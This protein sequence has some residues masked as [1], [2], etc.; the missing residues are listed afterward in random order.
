MI[1]PICLIAVAA[2]VALTTNE[3]KPLFDPPAQHSVTAHDLDEGMQA[4]KIGGDASYSVR[5][6]HVSAAKRTVKVV[7][8]ICDEPSL[9]VAMHTHSAKSDVTRE[10]LAGALRIRSDDALLEIAADSHR[11]ISYSVSVKTE[12]DPPARRGPI[13]V[14]GGRRARPGEK[15]L[16]R[17]GG[18]PPLAQIRH[19]RLERT[20]IVTLRVV[21]FGKLPGL[22]VLTRDR[23]IIGRATASTSRLL[24][25]RS[26]P[27]G[28]Y[29][30]RIVPNA[31]E[32]S[33]VTLSVT[34]A[35]HEAGFT[36]RN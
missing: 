25:R 3:V 5:W 8:V 35:A 22:E 36:K 6:H 27:A 19:L 32:L 30:L 2:A 24:F 28:E 20:S 7:K 14:D 10:A 4:F 17:V 33:T 31:A 26:L 29:V 16:I 1:P 21:A 23:K 18:D 9:S 13:D 12:H 34:V 15:E 11:T